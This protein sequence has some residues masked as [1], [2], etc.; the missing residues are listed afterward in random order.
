M[1]IR[2]ILYKKIKFREKSVFKEQREKIIIKNELLAFLKGASSKVV[3]A[4]CVC[5]DKQFLVDLLLKGWA[6]T[7]DFTD[8]YT[9]NNKYWEL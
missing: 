9:K 5:K 3:E 2:A 7:L 6:V 1:F 8:N 4:T